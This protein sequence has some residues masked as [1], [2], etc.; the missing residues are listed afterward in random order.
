MTD[1]YFSKQ[2]DECRQGFQQLVASAMQA[3]IPVP[4]FCA[5][6]NYYL[7]FHSAWLPANLIQAQRDFFGAHTYKRNDRE[8]VFHTEWNQTIH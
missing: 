6:L 2:L 1:A 3:G 7:S 5:S 4:G 8:G